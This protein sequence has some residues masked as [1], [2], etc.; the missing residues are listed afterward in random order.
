LLN[1]GKRDRSKSEV[2][3]NV[4]FIDAGGGPT[5]KAVIT[6]ED[7]K[8]KKSQKVEESKKVESEPAVQEVNAKPPA[9]LGPIKKPVGPAKA[10][11][12]KTDKKPTPTTT[13]DEEKKSSEDE[14]KKTVAPLKSKT[15]SKPNKPSNA[16]PQPAKEPA[17]KPILAKPSNAA[18]QPLK[19]SASKPTLAKPLNA[20]PPPVKETPGKP[21]TVPAIKPSNGVPK[22][23]PNLIAAQK[24]VAKP[25]MTKG[26]VKPIEIPEK[27]K[28][29]EP[30]V[31]KHETTGG[32][33]SSLLEGEDW[34]VTISSK[35]EL[36]TSTDPGDEIIKLIFLIKR[37]EKST[38]Y[39]K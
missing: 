9:K 11:P 20:A 19:E 34:K 15:S 38:I 35:H 14:V 26:P 8:K 28:I 18:P 5:K 23:K 10:P 25:A 13:S 21:L 24:S 32:W 39:T 7:P 6:A 16:A 30:D 36:I 33:Q 17:A 3:I 37:T 2:K 1:Q 31:T 22:I 12:K 27:E 29:I 4:D